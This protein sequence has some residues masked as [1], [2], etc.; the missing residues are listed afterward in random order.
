MSAWLSVLTLA[1]CLRTLQREAV[2]Y[3]R[4]MLGS[5]WTGLSLVLLITLALSAFVYLDTCPT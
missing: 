2:S 3:L 4:L 5:N 1:S